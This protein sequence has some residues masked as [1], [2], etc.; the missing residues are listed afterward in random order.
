MTKLETEKARKLADRDMYY[1]KCLA[2]NP[3]N[4]RGSHSRARLRKD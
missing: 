4:N 3:G 2:E 1:K